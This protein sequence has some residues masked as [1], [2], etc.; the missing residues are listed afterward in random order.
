MAVERKFIKEAVNRVLVKDYVKKETER[1]GYGGMDIQRTPLGTR[2]NI[3]AERPGMVI[4]RRGATINELTT[5]LHNKFGIENPQISVEEPNYNPGLN[6]Q[7]MAIKVAESL[8]RGWHFRRVGHSTTQRVMA[9]GAQGVIVEIAGKLTGQRKRREKFIQGHV[10]YCGET[11]L[12]LMDIGYAQCKKKLGVIGC[13]VRIMKKDAV[14]PD[15]VKIFAPGE[16][17]AVLA[18]QKARAA[19][20]AAGVQTVATDMG[21]GAAAPATGTQPS[22]APAQPTP[23]AAAP[24][25]PTSTGPAPAPGSGARRERKSFTVGGDGQ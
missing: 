15:T 3:V 24:N 4:G 5:N 7:I 13:T 17:E 12:T 22:P 1:A 21:A 20:T 11:A 10:K 19:A 23:A 18:A 6:A 9:S 8:E 16:K 2:V 14:L 25:V